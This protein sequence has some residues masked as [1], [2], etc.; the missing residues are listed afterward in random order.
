M[1]RERWVRMTEMSVG[2]N[3]CEGERAW[4][5]AERKESRE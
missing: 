5:K 3:S 4:A 2:V 1:S